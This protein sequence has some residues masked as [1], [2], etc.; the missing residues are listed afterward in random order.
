MSSQPTATFTR[1][2]PPLAVRCLMGIGMFAV[3]GPI[4]R[5]LDRLG[6]A[7]SFVASMAERRSR[8]AKSK[9]PLNTYTPTS[10][11][12]FVAAHVKSGTN[13]MMQIAHQLAFHGNAEYDHIHSVV[14]W[15]D[16]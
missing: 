13:W 16:V 1:K 7:P 8:A 11:D 5:V 4:I 6:R 15:P 2:M 3:A 10:H 14:A 12:V 9:N